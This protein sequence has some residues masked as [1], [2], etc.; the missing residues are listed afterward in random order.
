MGEKGTKGWTMIQSD[1]RR[2]LQDH[3]WQ[4]DTDE[5]LN[6]PQTGQSASWDDERGQW[7]DDANGQPL[8]ADPSAVS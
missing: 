8:T 7:V 2:M 1:S 3:G 4:G 5:G 6:N